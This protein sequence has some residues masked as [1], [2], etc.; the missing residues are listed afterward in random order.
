M[1]FENIVGNGA[2]A[3]LDISSFSSYT[4]IVNESKNSILGKGMVK[5]DND[6]DI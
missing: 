4:V 3:H 5:L 6:D 1:T 2:Y